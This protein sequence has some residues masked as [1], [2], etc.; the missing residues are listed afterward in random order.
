MNLNR[1]GIITS[2]GIISY[3]VADKEIKYLLICRKDSLGFIEFVRGKY[4]FNKEYIQRLVDEMTINEKKILLENDFKYIWDYLWINYSK[5]HGKYEYNSACEKF[6][7]LKMGMGGYTDNELNLDS[8]IKNSNTNWVTPE[9]GFP[10]G[11]RNYKEGLVKCAIREF[12]EETGLDQNK[13]DLISNLMPFDEIFIGSNY[14]LYKHTYYIANYFGDLSQKQF[15]KTE[16]SDMRW[17]TYEEAVKLIRF[18]NKERLGILKDIDV[19]LKKNI[20][21]N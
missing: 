16:V 2:Y 6:N 5:I 19:I 10:K 13:I 4:P 3:T 15:Q 9:W 12:K 7:K 20:I 21:I 18:Y 1:S 11:R 17:V 8:L 14:K